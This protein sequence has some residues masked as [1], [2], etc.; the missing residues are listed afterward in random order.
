MSKPELESLLGFQISENESAVLIQNNLGIEFPKIP[1]I[2]EL[3][4]RN[5]IQR[6]KKSG[7]IGTIVQATR[8]DVVGAYDRKYEAIFIKGDSLFTELH[9]NGHALL[10]SINPEIRNTIDDLAFMVSKRVMGRSVDVNKVEKIVTYRCFD[11]GI[12]Q[13]IALETAERLVDD[14]ESQDIESMKVAML[15]E[16]N[17]EIRNNTN[18]LINALSQ[19][20]AN[21]MTESLHAEALLNDPIYTAGYSFVAGAME[22]MVKSNNQIGKAL[23]SLIENPPQNFD[24]LENPDQFALSIKIKE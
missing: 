14:F 12:A 24:D 19:T 23:R 4:L 9:E 22:L 11:E 13:W 7:L 1:P 18:M 5:K 2:I 6:A 10:D 15:Q 8:K 20:G 16:S 3:N 21:V 17:Q